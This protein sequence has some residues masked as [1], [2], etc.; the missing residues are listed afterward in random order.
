V[1]TS[2]DDGATWQ[3]GNLG[4]N[5]KFGGVA[6]LNTSKFL[7]VGRHRIHRSADNGASWTQ[8]TF[9][10][11]TPNVLQT[12]NAVATDGA[13]K[14]VAV[15]QFLK[16]GSGA[17]LDRGMIQYSTDGGATFKIAMPE[18]NGPL[19]AVAFTG[20]NRFVAAGGG[21]LMY[22]TDGGVTW[23]N[24]NYTNTNVIYRRPTATSEPAPI[25]NIADIVASTNGRI[26]AVGG[27]SSNILHMPGVAYYSSDGGLSWNDTNY[28]EKPNYIKGVATNNQGRW[29]AVGTNI[30]QYIASTDNGVSWTQFADIST[31]NLWLGAITH[32]QGDKW[33]A[34]GANGMFVATSDNG[35]TWTTVTTGSQVS[36]YDVIC[37]KLN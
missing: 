5:V 19:T 14:V 9:Q 36:F 11:L 32:V 7:A 33:L 1:V 12:F 15:G 35:S 25:W 24:A 21:L 27:G 28:S 31:N 30:G 29:I 17:M 26:L 23:S 2:I 37:A 13:T 8:S 22:S 18:V 3:V 4:I 34:V 6:H 20:N 16:S 10:T